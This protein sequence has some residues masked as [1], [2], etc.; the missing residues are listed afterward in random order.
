MILP[1]S[2]S[3]IFIISEELATLRATCDR[4]KEGE[5]QPNGSFKKKSFISTTKFGQVIDMKERA[6]WTR[7]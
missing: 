4:R 5:N 6:L 7:N 1:S 3:E 2:F